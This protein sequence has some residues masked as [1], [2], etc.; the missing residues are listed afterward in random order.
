VVSGIC[1]GISDEWHQSF[2]P[3]RDATIWDVLFDAAGIVAD[4]FTYRI[5]M[6]RFSFFN[7]LDETLEREFTHEA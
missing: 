5:T 3:G 7:K 4:A 1:C 6:K 2:L